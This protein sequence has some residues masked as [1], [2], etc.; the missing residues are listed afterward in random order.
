LA[1]IRRTIRARFVV[2]PGDKQAQLIVLA[3]GGMLNARDAKKLNFFTLVL[4]DM[5]D[6][7]DYPTWFTVETP[8]MT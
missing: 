4:I 2:F 7:S 6:L 3:V 1:A 5:I 8:G